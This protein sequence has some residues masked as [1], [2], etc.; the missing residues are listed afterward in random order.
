M[1]FAVPLALALAAALLAPLA[2]AHEGD[3]EDDGRRLEVERDADGFE[4][5]SDR[6]EAGVHDRIRFRLE[7][8]NVEFRFEL[9]SS[10]D[11]TELEADLNVRLE[12]IVEFRDDGDGRLG[13]G[14]EIVQ[15]FDRSDLDLQGLAVENVTAGGVPGVQ[16]TA[17]Y[18][19]GGSGA[20][21]LRVTAFGN[22]TT[23]QGLEQSPVQ[24]KLDLLLDDFPFVDTD[25]QPAI[26]MR[27]KA[28]APD[29]PSLP[30]NGIS[31]T[32]GNLTAAFSW[33]T[34]ALVDGVETPVGTTVTQL[35]D[36]PPE[37]TL[38]VTFAYVR[39]TAIEHDP[40]FG[41][42]RAA[43]DGIL[44]GVTILGNWAFYAIG[45]VAALALVLP[46]AV[47]RRGRKAKG[48]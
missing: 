4:L 45:G 39:G 28:E 10:P 1:R 11:S 12:R 14:D 18:A 38:S 15:E 3:W 26:E 7:G 44:P 5:R 22:V 16:V 35:P 6:V 34:T 46:F 9:L 31:F 21:A 30:A 43:A 8:Q 48:P 36:Q 20:L 41:F 29:G 13:P 37:A 17:A 27:A 24:I 32:A 23:F 25:T 47:V 42:L 33:K 40:T 2:G 19:F